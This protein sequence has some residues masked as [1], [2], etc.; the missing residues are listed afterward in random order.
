M[1]LFYAALWLHVLFRK[2]SYY[3]DPAVNMPTHTTD[4]CKLTLTTK[5]MRSVPILHYQRRN[6]L[7]SCIST[8]S[9]PG[10][11]PSYLLTSLIS[12]QLWPYILDPVPEHR[13]APSVCG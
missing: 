11:R 12:L 3:I 10:V 13:K 9:D 7:Y 2:T 8:R 4:Y 1:Q 5:I 6:T